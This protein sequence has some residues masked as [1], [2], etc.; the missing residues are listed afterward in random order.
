VTSDKCYEPIVERRA[1][2][3]ADRLGGHD[4]YSA[5]KACVEVMVDAWRRSFG[6]PV[7]ATAR[8]GN[9]IGGGDWSDDRIVPDLARARARGETPTL[10]NPD[11]IRPWQH[12]LEPLSG[13]L[14][15]GALLAEDPSLPRAWN[16]GPG[17]EASA[18]VRHLAELFVDR[19]DANGGPAGPRP[20]AHSVDGAPS[21]RSFLAVDSSL[22]A[23]ELGWRQVLTF[24]ETVDM[25][26][27]FYA[28]ACARPNFQAR[29]L[30][31]AQIGAYEGLA[32]E[33]GVAWMPTGVRA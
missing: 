15:L 14:W 3:E 9:V 4:P 17:P 20:V 11:A 8:A 7:L 33:R 2:Q 30:L 19:W 27:A 29:R 22:A 6:A 10:R 23:A 1:H 25:T 16:F 13:Y 32:E 24:Q 12:V 21:E 26:A 28:K 31:L 18:S 5:S